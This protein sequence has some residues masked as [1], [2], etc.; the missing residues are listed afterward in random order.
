MIY[1]DNAASTQIRQE[2]LEVINKELV[3]SFANP[4]SPYSPARNSRIAVDNA[5][6]IF[7]KIMNCDDN[8]IIFTSGGTESDNTA[9]KGPAYALKNI[10]NH[11]ITTATEHHAVLHTCNNLEK[12]GFDITYLPTDKYGMVNREDVISAIR[13]NTILVSVIY[14]NN[15][16]GSINPIQEIGEAIKNY[17]G[18]NSQFPLFH[19]DAVQAAT[20]LDLNVDKLG[21]DLMSISAHK[22]N[23]PKGIGALY[24]KNGI[25]FEPL[26]TGGGQER[27]K[28]SGTENIAFISG[29]AEAIRLAEEEKIKL[30]KMIM[31]LKNKITNHMINKHKDILI[32]GHPTKSLPNIINLTIPNVRADDLISAL[33]LEDI[34]ISNGSACTSNSLEPSHVLKSIGMEANL[35]LNTI[36]ISLGRNNT[37]SE[38]IHFLN[39]IDKIIERIRK[40]K[41]EFITNN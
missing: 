6:K 9:I 7:S 32:N 4:S 36:R 28:R 18:K 33:D 30:N 27:Q 16:L 24:M 35:A 38:I 2:V 19:T 37:E 5:R 29:S 31:A 25:P 22:F 11:I 10:G 14:A 26:I 12:Q 23:G 21:V 15:E 17:K 40:N 34:C 8:E 1:L 13:E 20:Y 39:I 41:K 3:N